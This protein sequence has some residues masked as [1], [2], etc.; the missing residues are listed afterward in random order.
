MERGPPV[1]SSAT[2]GPRISGPR[3][4]ARPPLADYG[5][6]FTMT[7]LEVLNPPLQGPAVGS[8]YQIWK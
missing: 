3:A 8:R 6:K 5:M 4:P 7:P 2:G 1:A